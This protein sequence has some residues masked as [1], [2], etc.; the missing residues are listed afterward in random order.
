MKNAKKWGRLV[1]MAGSGLVYGCQP[2]TD[3]TRPEITSVT[4]DGLIGENH[5]VH[6]GE[7]MQVSLDL[8][9]NENLRQVKINVHPADDGH[10]HGSGSGAVTQPNVGTWTYS[11]IID[12]EGIHAITQLSLNVPVNIAGEWHLEVM[13]I[14]ASGNEA[15]EKVVNLEVDNPALPVISVIT[16]PTSNTEPLMILASNPVL[17]LNVAVT[18]ASGVDSLFVQTTNAV[19]EVVFSQSLDATDAVEFTSGNIE[20]TFPSVGLYNVQVRALD[21]NGFENLWV[22]QVEVQ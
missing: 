1:L 16:N 3:T 19:D 21:V 5:L 10:T 6:A 20:M 11:N 2:E 9:D 14:D 7:A 17:S 12:L 18:D 4:V 22:R 8:R 13:A 15:I